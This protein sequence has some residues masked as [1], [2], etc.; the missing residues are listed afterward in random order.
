MIHKSIS[1]ARRPNTQVDASRSLRDT[2]GLP[3]PG[4]AAIG[5]AIHEGRLSL[6]DQVISFFP[7]AVPDEPDWRLE[8]MR[9]RDLLSMSTGH[10]GE[11]LRAFSF[12]S[13]SPSTST[14][15]GVLDSEFRR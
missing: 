14:K 6:D 5:L 11:D 7:D 12:D 13:A 4:P 15:L 9:I 10:H 3:F 1:G 8:A 2:E